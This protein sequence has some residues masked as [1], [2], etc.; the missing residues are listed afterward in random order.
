MEAADV[1][2]VSPAVQADLYVQDYDGAIA[3]PSEKL[4]ATRMNAGGGYSKCPTA[5]VVFPVWLHPDEVLRWVNH[6]KGTAQ[7]GRVTPA[8]VV[9]GNTLFDAGQF[10]LVTGDRG[11]F[12]VHLGKLAYEMWKNP[13]LAQTQLENDLRAIGAF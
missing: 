13:S 3:M 7:T 4:Y 6:V 1:Q 2:S 10:A 12:S 9:K 8:E 5:Y 11:E